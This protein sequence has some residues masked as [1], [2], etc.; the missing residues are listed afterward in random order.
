[1]KRLLIAL[2]A[3]IVLL[4][5]AALQREGGV[6]AQTGDP[7]AFA[8]EAV[9]YYLPA[10]SDG[11]STAVAVGTPSFTAGTVSGG[12]DACAIANQLPTGDIDTFVTTGTEATLFS[13]DAGT[14]AIT[15]TGAAS[16][17]A[18]V[19]GTLEGWSL[20]VT[21]S[22]GQGTGT[23]DTINVT[24]KLVNLDTDREALEALYD[25]T[26]GAS[27]TTSTTWKMPTT[28]K[29]FQLTA[30]TSAGG[31]IGYGG[32]IGSVRAG[33]A[34]FTLGGTT[35]TLNQLT[36]APSTNNV[37]LRVS[38]QGT[39]SHFDDLAL[40]IGSATLN[41]EDATET[42]PSG[43][44]Q[45]AWSAQSTVTFA[46][47]NFDP[48]LASLDF[49]PGD[50][51]G[52]TVSGGRVTG[53]ALPDNNLV[54]ALPA[55]MGDLTALTTLDLSGNAGLTD[56]PLPAAWTS[57]TALTALNL[58]TT[59]ACADTVHS[60]WVAAITSATVRTCGGAEPAFA[61][62]AVTYYLQ[63][64]SDGSSTA[65]AIGTP[66]FTAG[67]GDTCAIAN[68]LPAGDI[69]TFATTGTEAT[70]FSINAT[71]CAITYTGAA[72]DSART[73]GTLEGWSLRVTL[74]DGAGTGADDT[75]D[76][77]VKLV[78]LDT[79]KA[80]LE[81]LYDAT[82]GASWT[83]STTWKQNFRVVHTWT[84][85]SGTDSDGNVG[86]EQGVD[87]GTW[88]GGTW[89]SPTTG[90]SCARVL[91]EPRTFERTPGGTIRFYARW[92]AGCNG[93][94]WAGFG[95]R[96][97][98]GLLEGTP[99]G[100][101][102]IT[103]N[104]PNPE[105]LIPASG[106]F[107]IDVVEYNVN[108]V[109]DWHGVTVTSGRVTGLALASNNLV[110]ALPAAMGDL[111]ALTTLNL[112]GNVGLADAA[113][114]ASW[115]SM[116]ALTTLN[117][118]TTGAC[119]LPVHG[120][121]VAAITSAT[122]NT[123]GGAGPAFAEETVAYY[124]QADSDG[125]TTAIA[126]GAP[127]FTAGTVSGGTDACSVSA[128]AENASTDPADH[129][130]TGTAVTGF[131]ATVSGTTCAIAYAGTGIT[132]TAGTL[133]AVS[134]TVA[135]N[136]DQ[137]SDPDTILVTV[138][139]VNLDTDAAALEALYDATGGA[140]WTTSTNWKAD[141]RI[142]HTWTVTVASFG[143][144]VG[145]RDGDHG[146]VSGG[147]WDTPHSCGAA[148]VDRLD[149]FRRHT[150]DGRIEIR[151][152]NGNGCNGALWTGYGLYAFNGL[153]KTMGGPGNGISFNLAN[154]ATLFPASGTV[155]LHVIQYDPPPSVWHG[156]TVTGGR[157]TGL[158]LANNNLVGALPAAMGDLTALTTLNLSGNS[159]LTD[160]PLPASWTSMTAL[161]TLNLGTTGACVLPV[162]GVW[163]AAITSATVDTCAA[164]AFAATSASYR[165]DAGATSAAIGA[166]AFSAGTLGGT[167]ACSVSAAA[168]NASADPANH[169][170][171]GTA[172]TGFTATVSGTTC[173]IAYAGTGFTRT[174][175]TLEAI[176]L[177]V[178]VSDGVG[179]DP[180]DTI[181][182][183]V[184]LLDLD[185][186]TA[187]LEAIYDATGGA[188]WT[189]ST[190]WKQNFR[191]VHTWTFTS[192]T[193]S[194]G[195]VG[196]SRG[197][198]GSVSGGTWDS[199]TTG[200]G[201]T[202][203]V[204]EPR[205]FERTSGGTIRFFARQQAACGGANWAGFGVRAF[206]GLFEG[207]PS[208]FSFLTA[209]P[210]NPATL[211]PA[212]GTFT[213][214]VIQYVNTV[215]DWHGVT[216]TNGR[217][218]GLAL[219]DNN[220]V[221]NLH[222]R[223]GDLSKL[224]SLDLS[225]NAGLSAASVSALSTWT[226]G[227]TTLNVEGTSI[228]IS[229]GTTVVDEWLMAI[230]ARP[231]GSVTT[232]DC[233]PRFAAATASG[234]L[235]ADTDG[236]ST[237]I[238]IIAPAFAASRVS[239]GTD[240]CA[241]GTAIANA[242]ADP[243]DF[244]TTGTAVT[245]FTAT[246]S[247]GTC[248]LAYT[249]TGLTA[250][251]TQA[252]VS[253]AVTL[254]DGA[255]A[256]GFADTSVDDTVNV[257]VRLV[258]G[259]TDKAA[260]EAFHDGTGGTS[261]TTRTDW[262][263][264]ARVVHTWNFTSGAYTSGGAA[265]VGYSRSPLVGSR[266]GV[267]W[268]SP[269][270]GHACPPPGNREEPD[271][272]DRHTGTGEIR[273]RMKL[274]SA[275]SG[276]LWTG[277]GVRAFNGLLE[278][279][280][281]NSTG[282]LTFNLANPETLIPAAG[283]TFSLNVIQYL[284][285]GAWHG[286]TETSGRVTGLALTDNNLRGT[287]LPAGLGDLSQLTNLDLSDNPHLRGTIPAS[288]TALGNLLTLD[289]SGTGVCVDATDTA[290][291]AWLAAIRAKTGGEAL[292]SV[293]GPVFAED[294]A[295]LYLDA[296]ASG[297]VAVGTPAFREGL[298]AGATDTCAIS[299]QAE[300][301]SAVPAMHATT[302]TAV[303][304]FTINSAT[305]AITYTG[306]GATRT[307]GALE[308]YSLTITVSD[309][310]GAPATPDDSIDVT[311]KLVN[312]ATDEAALN[313]FYTATTGASWTANTGWG[314]T[315]LSGWH[316]V[317]VDADGRVTGLALPSNNLAGAFPASMADL[318]RLTSLDL[319]GNAG[320]T[321][322]DAGA[323]GLTRLTRLTSLDLAGA[324]ICEHED[325]TATD[326]AVRVWLGGLRT[327]G[328]TV[329][330]L[331]CGEGG[332][333]FALEEITYVLDAGA[334]GSTTA[335]AIGAPGFTAGIAPG[336]TDACAIANQLPTG[337]AD[338]FA[339]TGTDATLFSIDASTCAI[340][341]TGAASA[342]A[343]VAGTLEGWSLT[344]TASDAVDGAGQADASVDS[345]IKVTVKLVNGDTD[346]ETLNAFYDA[347]GGT[348]WTT[349]TSWK[350]TSATTIKTFQLTSGSGAGKFGYRIAALGMLGAVRAGT[351]S[352]T[353]SGTSYSFVTI[354]RDVNDNTVTVRVTPAGTSSDFNGHAMVIGS[355][356]LNFED[357]T[358]TTPTGA[359]EWT[360]SGQT[361][362]TFGGGNFDPVLARL[363]FRPGTWHGVTASGG[364][365][366]GLALA[367]N[368]LTGA[369]PVSLNELN[370]LT[371]LDLSGNAGLT[372][373]IH[374]AI[375]SLTA[376]TNLDL[377][378]NALSGA[379]PAELTGLTALTGLD[380]GGNALSGA[381]PTGIG[382]LTA[383]TG[384]DLGDNALTGDIPTGIGALTALTS[385][386][387][388]GNAGL[389]GGIPVQLST[390]TALTSLDLGGSS[391]LAGSIPL[392]LGLL[393]A[394]TSLDLSRTGATGA[395]PEEL[396]ALTALTSL[397]LSGNSGLSGSIP[398][399]LAALVNLVS[400]DLSDTGLS[401]DIPPE[402]DALTEVTALDLRNAL[403]CVEPTAET[404]VHAWLTARRMATGTTIN[405]PACSNTGANERGPAFTEAA[406][407]YVL[408]SGADGSGTAIAIGAPAVRAGSTG[409]SADACKITAQVAN[410][411]DDAAMHTVTGTAVTLFTID[412]ATC[413]ITYTGAASAS[414]RAAGT[415]EAYSL[416]I[417][418]TDGVN[419]A[420]Q[421]DKRADGTIKVTVK[422]V[423]GDTDRETLAALY[424]ATGGASWTTGTN[425][426]ASGATFPAAVKEFQLT[427]GSGSNQVGYSQSIGSVRAGTRTFTL[428]GTTYTLSRIIRWPSN[429]NV[430]LIVTPA[431][432][433]SHFDGAALTIGSVTL[434][435]D[436]AAESTSSSGRIFLWS[437]RTDVTFGSSGNLDVAL[438]SGPW[439]GATATGGRVTG[440]A[441]ADNNL[442]GTLLA[443]L[444]ELNKLTS[445]DLGG[446]AGL[447]GSIPA[448]LGRLTGLTSLDLSGGGWTG[449]IPAAL[450]DLTA[451]TSLDL[452]GNAGLRGPIPAALGDLAA[453][454]SLDLSGATGLTGSIP[455][456]IT[457]LTTLT[458]LDLSDGGWT[459]SIPA[460]LGDLTALTTLDLS[461]NAG[462]R[463]AIPAELGALT[464][465]TSLDLGGNA[466]TGA[467][468]AQLSALTALVSL[469]LRDN[470][471]LTGSIP[472]E[473]DALTAVTTL[474]LDGTGV[475]VNPSQEA[476][477][478]AWLA[479]I[480][481]G[482]GELRVNTCN[483]RAPAFREAAATRNLDAGADGS[484]T[485]IAIGSFAATPATLSGAAPVC[486]LFAYANASDDPAD[487]STGGTA[488]TDFTVSS[489][490]SA[491]GTVCTVTYTGSGATRTDGTLEAYSL[492]L[493]IRDGVD[494]TGAADAA[495]IDDTI[496]VTVKLVDGTTDRTALEA[497][498]DA[499]GGA[500]WTT[501]TNWKTG[502]IFNPR[503]LQLTSGSGSNIRG[504]SVPHSLGSVRTGTATFTLEDTTYTLTVL[505]RQPTSSNVTLRVTP[506]GTASHFDGLA[507]VIGSATLNFGDATETSTSGY[508]QFVWHTRTDVTFNTGNLDAT[509]RTAW[510][511][512]T[513]TS[514]RATALSL[515]DN[516]LRGSIPAALGDLSGLTS[517]DLSD[518]AGLSGGIPAALTRLTNLLTLNL[519]DTRVCAR[520]IGDA[521]VNAWLDGI[522]AKAGG[523]VTLGTCPT[524]ASAPA[525]AA[526]TVTVAT[527]GDAPPNA[528]Y[529]LRLVCG[530]SEYSISLAA[531]GS[532]SAPVSPGS[533]CS[534][535]VTNRRGA[536]EARGEFTGRA[537]G[538]GISA[539]VTLVHEADPDDAEPNAQLERALTPGAAFVRWQG[540][541]TPVG[542]AVAALTLHVGAVHYWDAGAQGWLSWFPDSSE[543][544]GVNTLATL[545]E[546][547]IY[548]FFAE[549]TPA[550]DNGA[551]P[552]VA[553]MS[554]AAATAQLERTLTAGG[555]FARWQGGTTPVARAVG[556]LTLGV[557]A[558]HL[559]DA[560]AQG[561]RTWFPGAEALGVN[562]LTTLEAGGIY[563]VFS[564]E[565]EAAP[566]EEATDAEARGGGSG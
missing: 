356:T 497:F 321:F 393:T 396:G 195:D 563:F 561:W 18:R 368:N 31:S 124:L 62:E 545:E 142:V 395:I 131:T 282:Y 390:L 520:S 478:E 543:A 462:L 160:A 171:T 335:V 481:S 566:A 15:Y 556:G 336:G 129:A 325:G 516:G 64:G 530:G 157:V 1:M 99:S 260:L 24:V 558:V 297:P 427:S 329:D 85:T 194:D 443:E 375:A 88:S 410:A 489:A 25:A 248:V 43:S 313:A 74:S 108:T 201:C 95:V 421:L 431:G 87:Q 246:A 461:G 307:A 186:D 554:A 38:P 465:L 215:S 204:D 187:A 58:G 224:T 216:V 162:H 53:L 91:E 110:G 519:E 322:P 230:R 345:T 46:A 231:G 97:F 272:F 119:V 102:F 252:A 546:G 403:I 480:R 326:M 331:G 258:S 333:A 281:L 229:P 55:A 514:G 80:A 539:T 188:S 455:A 149:R 154:P 422:L 184:K 363:D 468:P 182:V 482:S 508:R 435:L 509:L 241:I 82:G 467:I 206:N 488:T 218:T 289:L 460:A 382:S 76:V 392:Q 47:G 511:G 470:A 296:G 259:T 327:A 553:T 26:G 464:A 528:R 504:Y 106:T 380:L 453:L 283:G 68:Q 341:Y 105:T 347:T 389:T 257:T 12:T 151:T 506:A 376:L 290:V 471:G 33:T 330:I 239:G 507:L 414:T 61:E 372:G 310:R 56:G 255:D 19:A 227:L 123:C 2:L 342:S 180:D 373:S 386:D 190:T 548:M 439:H 450:G 343:R 276:A 96:A 222:W 69:D 66:S 391:G 183:T 274:Q 63:A 334:N 318:N 192:G 532:Y 338:T 34:T 237:A 92:Q 273:L 383:L 52:V 381:I 266:D 466:H 156:V 199:P 89:D 250:S 407:T 42:T 365:V 161:T 510:H 51:H 503:T 448:A 496:N 454:T 262:K 251:A 265:R 360:W 21:L 284:T 139:L 70:L 232:D 50:W 311:V 285:A 301:A 270:T 447:T 521:R 226:P 176:S 355:V 412:S 483:G 185:T 417:T 547:G 323:I 469:D 104:P 404:R 367:D 542:E 513:A 302:G 529:G 207:R 559:W 340:T 523:S 17:S 7:P 77:T 295:T 525:V 308:A 236:S 8:E 524:S 168:E 83:T 235:D 244:L 411:D 22:D 515:P 346:A 552:A 75:I 299:A 353:V 247:S 512:V 221:G 136:D 242:S 534:L 117:L 172:V 133:E 445:L 430:S 143:S 49:R 433:A 13:I 35:Y 166:P 20:R 319:S 220:L 371:S 377:G 531:G 354:L 59:G 135:V 517:L 164:P 128:A 107:T 426:K 459:G 434:N 374:P 203:I 122:V 537:A 549:G 535:S 446:N 440:L 138:K 409:H 562:T 100:I 288:W 214:D 191:V 217:V 275:C 48:V 366:T 419:D 364:R 271:N 28:I 493:S 30:G 118:G 141:F 332:P 211:I 292:V 337:D 254:S 536:L 492:D 39:A 305:C 344:V 45:F 293:C 501:G 551:A 526:V 268:S 565:R 315:L 458:S 228:C 438:V 71:T 484:T 120:V 490:L 564:E 179:T 155:Q 502:N 11:S 527:E 212:S 41:L 298:L 306:A 314:V 394:L 398:A 499:A 408:D 348:S 359:R 109:S 81:A 98:N 415:L 291:N 90:H 196:Y 303:T 137:G 9:T 27:W 113:L 418:V 387:L 72:G 78:N 429:N 243:S 198:H 261:W 397:D 269:T 304:L 145:Y 213:L 428:G 457:S 474:R 159:G 169:A 140:S 357:A 148:V 73:A 126:V 309:G 494:A 114:P 550:P 424:D 178:T 54:G 541:T 379:I 103:A 452:G 540:G 234:N 163:V 349:D 317:T 444:G 44:R 370:K 385:L 557:T 456:A 208:G 485:A 16:A 153:I 533:V 86:Y 279:V 240:A 112:S 193:A 115:T 495:G 175:G 4:T 111:T 479:A 249:G 324:G 420:G 134:L 152:K 476:R 351:N 197:E 350:T 328:A 146:S 437:A 405:V 388:G 294:A 6:G 555:A 200:H 202:A 225:G 177:T 14:C 147:D 280:P 264:D 84:L 486:V 378:G 223:L 238:T 544:L 181:A 369:L 406:T 560:G 432:T 65:I 94:N 358:E 425:W 57:M 150:G 451:L 170:T 256:D 10:G 210:A 362:V 165:L 233:S 205:N 132:R 245:G 125:S 174:A 167:D 500:S 173:A 32:T 491:A 472:P 487:F 402:L 127:S 158:A 522:R 116:T 316:G 399:E 538:G 477:A 352:A 339:T 475:C 498:Y 505:I 144:W 29:T 130:T 441:L 278:G 37:T 253:V 5:P 401:G 93:A 3:A 60:T 101:N 442:V 449:S 263:Q 413:A 286:V 189:T 219:P 400:L 300:N 473:L 320:L 416:T 361:G 79:D 463:G 267:L 312:A 209:N 67:A 121:W 384:L 36:R 23:D 277:F 40:T 423:N 436:D 287:S 518:N